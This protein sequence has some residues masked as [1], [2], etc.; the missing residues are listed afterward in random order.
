[1][2]RADLMAE[3]ADSATVSSGGSIRRCSGGLYGGGL[4]GDD[5]A[6]HGHV[7]AMRI[8]AKKIL[9]KCFSIIQ[10]SGDVVKIVEIID[11]TPELTKGAAKAAFELYQLVTHGFLSSELRIEAVTNFEASSYGGAPT[12]STKSG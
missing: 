8:L 10:R 7:D 5:W 12:R 1:M 11:E 4:N 6:E 2:L 3:S 9:N